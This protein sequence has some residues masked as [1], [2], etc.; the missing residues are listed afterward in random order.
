V[1]RDWLWGRCSGIPRCCRLFFC[2]FW[3]HLFDHGDEIRMVRAPGFVEWYNTILERL[4]TELVWYVDPAEPGTRRLDDI[5]RHA[6]YIPCP[7]CLLSLS[8]VEVKECHE[9]CG[10][11][12]QRPRKE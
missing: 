1:R 2:L 7:R 6:G 8:F 12:G 5:V 9:S 3:A 10:C 11:P 4:A